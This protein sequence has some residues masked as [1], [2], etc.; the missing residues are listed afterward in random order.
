MTDAERLEL[1][2]ALERE[3]GGLFH[4]TVHDAS[5]AGDLTMDALQGN[6]H[7]EMALLAIGHYCR[8]LR[9]G[10]P[11]SCLMCGDRLFRV[12]RLVACIHPA[13]ERYTTCSCSGFCAPCCDR[14]LELSPDELTDRLLR[15]VRHFI[16]DA[17]ALKVSDQVG[18][19]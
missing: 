4:I 14:M 8:E 2:D 16:P 15:A 5:C 18:H 11:A 10:H 12:P 17:R 9:A 3:A 1:L 7:S 6:F 13:A 19:A